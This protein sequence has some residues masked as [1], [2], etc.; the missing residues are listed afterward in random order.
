MV[1][2]PWVTAH[3][4]TEHGLTGDGVTEPQVMVQP[5]VFYELVRMLS[6]LHSYA[7]SCWQQHYQGPM[8]DPF[9]TKLPQGNQ[10]H[11]FPQ[12]LLVVEVDLV[13]RRDFHFVPQ[14]LRLPPDTGAQH[15]LFQ[16]QMGSS[17][18]EKVI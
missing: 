8:A 1:T 10:I 9:L 11:C 5:L 15:L 14:W 6:Y 2:E 13:G 7:Y 16:T 4:V 18:W 3:E 12:G 17:C